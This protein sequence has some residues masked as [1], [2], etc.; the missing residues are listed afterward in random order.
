MGTAM[1]KDSILCR[2]PPGG[3]YRLTVHDSEPKVQ[4]QPRYVAPKPCGVW[5]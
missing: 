5:A 2:Q 3:R 1:A 4:Q